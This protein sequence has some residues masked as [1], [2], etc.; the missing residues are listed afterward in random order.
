MF[1]TEFAV[2][3]TIGNRETVLKTFPED[4]KSAAL[5]YGAEA[6]QGLEEGVIACVLAEYEEANQMRD[7]Q[8]REF[9]VW[10]SG[11]SGAMPRW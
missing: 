11:E 10:P 2:T 5:A 7:H 1:V 4:Q 3:H 8:C 9:E 6:A